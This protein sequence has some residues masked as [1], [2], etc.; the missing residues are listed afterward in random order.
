[1]SQDTGLAALGEDAAL[2]GAAGSSNTVALG[3]RLAAARRAAGLS[4]GKLG[5]ALGLRKDQISKIESGKRRLGVS[6]LALA[7][8]ALGTSVRALVGGDSGR[9][10]LMVAARLAAGSAPD[11]V[12]PAYRRA[13]QLLELDDLLTRAVDLPP[14]ALSAGAEQVFASAQEHSA[15]SL[16]SVAAAR[17]QGKE[18]AELAREALNLGSDGLLDLAAVCEQHFG[19]DV[20]FAP[21]GE[22]IDG[23]CVHSESFALL[24]AST[25]Y[26]E[27]HLRFTLAHELGH[28]L[29]ADPRE[30]IDEH[31]A[32]M[33]SDDLVEKRANAFAG[34]LLMP[35]T[36][37]TS[38][39]TWLGE[40]PGQVSERSL[41]HLMEHFGVSLAALIFQ[42]NLLNWVSYERGQELRQLKVHALVDR[43]GDVAVTGAATRPSRARRAPERLVRHA[44][45]AARDQRLGV[46]VVAS[47]L[48]RE[49]DEQLWAEVMRDGE[50]DSRSAVIDAADILV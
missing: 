30:V 44:L 20:A 24:M 50:P 14:A 22:S 5:E 8:A 11:S 43:H 13:R 16:T 4:G 46:S 38:T 34:H 47:L 40:Q 25:D 35:A 15:R 23:L 33:F 45:S 27:G 19:V 3:Q 21:W 29:F 49:D 17:R 7:A 18:I 32:Q 42:L 31:A 37:M 28:H 26:P 1:M 6:E 39:L 41:V 2:T 36:G 48:E 10:H 9:S 12:A